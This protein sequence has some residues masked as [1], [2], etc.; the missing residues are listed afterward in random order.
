MGR[1]FRIRL[2]DRTQQGL[3]GN[4]S[5]GSTRKKIYGTA[6]NAV[7]AMLIS[8]FLVSNSYFHCGS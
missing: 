7:C 8:Y 4:V 3:M 6:I 5:I 1:I 2:Y